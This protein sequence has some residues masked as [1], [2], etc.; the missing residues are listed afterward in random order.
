M[1]VKYETATF[2]GGCFWCMVQP[3][4]QEKGVLQ[5][6]SGYAG[7]KEKNPTYH[8]VSSGTTGHREAVQIQYDPKKITYK[9]LLD[10]FWRQIDPT[11]AGGQF[12]DRGKQYMTAIFYH[13]A[14]QKKL[15]EKSKQ[16][17]ASKKFRSPLMTEILPFTT[18]YPAEEYHQE[19]Y[20]KN[21]LGYKTYKLLSGRSAYQ[22]RVWKDKKDSK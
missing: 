11:D 12:G 16:E 1:A 20:K 3:F 9:K 5:V 15:A 22:K 4:Q 18:F 13:S 7:G 2:A 17:F 14:E 21:P 6:I 10:I 19:Y 8:E